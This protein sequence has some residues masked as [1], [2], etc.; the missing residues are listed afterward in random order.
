MRAEILCVGTELLIGQVVNTNATF[1]AQELA[2][3]GIDVYWIVTVGDN[4]ARLDA[5]LREAAGRADLVIL[6]GGLG[7]TDD[8]ITIEAI[9]RLIG[10][11]PVE[12]PEVRAHIEALFAR[13]GR[14]PRPDV[15]KMAM[16]P[17]SATAIPNPAGSAWGVDVRH[18]GARF[19]AFPGVPSE[20]KAMWRGV[21][22]S[23]QTGA[24][25]RSVLLKYAGIGES[26]L[27]ALVAP[28]LERPNP[29]VAPYV[30][31]GEV[32]LRVTAKAT[33]EAEAQAL[34]APV[35][36]ELE[37]IAPY[38]FGRD[39]ETLPSVIGARL[40]A[41]G[42]TLAVAESCTGGLL[43]SRLTDVI[44]SSAYFVGGV[45]AYAT[46]TKALALGLDAAK[47]AS[48]GVV[49][50][51]VARDL[52][53][54][55]RERLGASWGIGITGYAS[56]GAGVPADQVGLVYYGVSNPRETR[57]ACG[58]YGGA[59]RETVKHRATQDALDLLRRW[60]ESA[61]DA[62]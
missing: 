17:P 2:S 56:E 61:N 33:G 30:S 43:A 7:P 40:A 53:E 38:Y 32:H 16:L 1:L 58:R 41:R 35:V 22:P 62:T 36:A 59:P 15:F 46:R 51:D 5:A 23:L 4:F 27:A 49:T 24:V 48:E 3:L 20:L 52:A 44:G 28:Y 10:E 57:V 47:L 60:L 34:L 21:V 13:R 6:S 37:T 42:E 31:T 54:H 11:T 50:P 8:D 45:V 29:T 26:D 25:I 9:A 14:T 18:G 12:R 39:A 55:V 19:L